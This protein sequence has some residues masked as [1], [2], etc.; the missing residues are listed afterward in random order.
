LTGDAR[1]GRFEVIAASHESRT[2]KFRTP[3][4]QVLFREDKQ[5][6][7]YA[8]SIRNAGAG[9]ALLT[10]DNEIVQLEIVR[11]TGLRKARLQN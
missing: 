10:I 5:W 6:H 7:T 4:G 8:L 3:R 1:T 9:G 11:S 2:L